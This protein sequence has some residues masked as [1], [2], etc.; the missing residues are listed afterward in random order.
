MLLSSIKWLHR[1]MTDWIPKWVNQLRR[2]N[3]YSIL[4][5]LNH[6]TIKYSSDKN[7]LR[8]WGFC[9]WNWNLLINL[10]P[11]LPWQQSITALI[12]INKMWDLK[13]IICDWWYLYLY[14]VEI[15]NHQT[16]LSL[17][18]AGCLWCFLFGT[19]YIQH[20]YLLTG[21]VIYYYHLFILC[22]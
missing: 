13:M 4:I 1:L 21:N 2:Y 7:L 19:D 15:K 17:V 10:L 6:L 5:A 8:S 11:F 16:Q 9:C 18:L 20:N 3:S 12:V 14:F 22:P